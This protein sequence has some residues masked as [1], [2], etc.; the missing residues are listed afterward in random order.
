MTPEQM[1]AATTADYATPPTAY[2]ITAQD[3]TAVALGADIQD[4]DSRPGCPQ[5][6]L[7]TTALNLLW[8]SDTAGR[9]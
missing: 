4:A 6:G 1:K 9:R 5:N 7:A 3:V 2:T 8:S